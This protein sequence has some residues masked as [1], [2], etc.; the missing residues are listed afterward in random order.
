MSIVIF[1]ATGDLTWR[2]LIPALFNLYC[3]RELPPQTRI[4]GFSNESYTDE[5]LRHRLRQ[6]VKKF[7]KATFDSVTWDSFAAMLNYF[8]GDLSVRESFGQLETFLS[9]LEGGPANRLYYL[10]TSPTLYDVTISNLGAAEMASQHGGGRNIIVEKPFGRDLESAQALNHTL[11]ATFDES[12]I[13][14]IDHYLGKETAQNIMFFRFA[15][16]VFESVWNRSHIDNVQITVAEDVDVEH[17]AIY[18]DKAGVIRDMFQNHLLQLITLV[19]MEPPASFEADELRNEKVKVLRAVRPIALGDTVRGQYDGYCTTPGV[20]SD[21]QT[22]TFAALKLYIDN[23]RWQGVPFYLRSGKGLARKA[24]EI[25]LQFKRPPRGMFNLPGGNDCPPNLLSLCIQPDESICFRFE[26]KIPGMP[27]TTRSADMTFSYRSVFG[28]NAIPEAYELLLMDAL[29]GDASLFTRND[30]IE[31]AWRI[32]DPIID[33][34]LTGD[35][36][37][38]ESYPQGSW[39]PDSADIVPGRDGCQWQFGCSHTGG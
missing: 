6:G 34:W 13:Y 21:S 30:E 39:G 18:Y 33:G 25:N 2:K 26:T 11:H 35:T 32:V 8:R 31:A 3:K 15:N 5:T 7:S 29:Q 16:S 22:P 28:E 20:A 14:R 38:L 23:W 27:H 37:P 24:T 9:K 17:R 10:A 12:Q 36:P 4:V 19:A 1:G